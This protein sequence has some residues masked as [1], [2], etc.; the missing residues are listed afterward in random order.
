MIN[1]GFSASF[2]HI[3]RY[4]ATRWRIYTLEMEALS[5]VL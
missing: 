4:S 5:G 3:I 2:A 1:E